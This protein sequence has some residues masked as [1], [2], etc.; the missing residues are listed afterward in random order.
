MEYIDDEKFKETEEFVW[1]YDIFGRSKEKKYCHHCG[2]KDY[3]YVGIFES[4]SQLES[5]EHF[6]KKYPDFEG[7]G[8]MNLRQYEKQNDGWK[9]FTSKHSFIFEFTT[10]EC[11]KEIVIEI[12][13]NLVECA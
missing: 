11:L 13:K 8:T 2:G 3:E 1:L 12:A 5:M 6:M 7:E 9:K 10:I 4:L